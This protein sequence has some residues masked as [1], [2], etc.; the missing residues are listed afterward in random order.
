[1]RLRDNLY[2]L[3]KKEIIPHTH[4]PP[5][6]HTW[7][8]SDTEENY[9]RNG[10]KKYSIDDVS[11]SINQH[12]YR[13]KDFNLIDHQA[14]KILVVG[15]SETFGIGLP[16][17]FRYSEVLQTLIQGQYGIPV[18]AINLGVPAYSIDGITRLLYQTVPVLRPHYVFCLFPHPAR[19]EYI[20]FDHDKT[21]AQCFCPSTRGTDEDV[22]IL[23]L[24]S[25]EWDF[26]SLIK[27][28]A[29]IERCLQDCRWSWDTWINFAGW[30]PADLWAD[31][32]DPQHYR[33]QQYR[34]TGND[35]TARDNMHAGQDY[36]RFLASDLMSDPLLH[37]AIVEYSPS[38][39]GHVPMLDHQPP[40]IPTSFPRSGPVSSCT[41]YGAISTSNTVTI[42]N[43]KEGA[44]LPVVCNTAYSKNGSAYTSSVDGS[45]YPSTTAVNGDTFTLQAIPQAWSQQVLI[46]AYDTQT[47]RISLKFL[48]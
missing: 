26:F 27:N 1:M 34:R 11:Y 6:T 32:F 38:V 33:H 48:H 29:L 30:I 39:R 40:K 17:Q 20:N 28:L 45:G 44:S 5:G 18:E 36:H 19:R 12:G 37:A 14:F 41:P 9:R 47:I 7:F 35:H 23:S 42:T 21:Y 15:C 25:D 46:V 10:N 4:L 16:I 13:T 2:H 43:L 3:W 24:S 22:A 8:G 31:Y